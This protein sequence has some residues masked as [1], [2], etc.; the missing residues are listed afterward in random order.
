MTDPNPCLKVHIDA[1]HKGIR[2]KCVDCDFTSGRK[3]DLN[4]H[5]K[6][7]SLDKI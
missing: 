5:M 4:K 3:G 6:K 7:V 2:H 1:V